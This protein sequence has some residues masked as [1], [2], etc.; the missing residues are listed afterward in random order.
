MDQSRRWVLTALSLKDEQ[1]EAEILAKLS[2]LL[3]RPITEE[4]QVVYFLVEL[5]KALEIRGLFTQYPALRF[6]C[7]WAVHTRMDRAGAEEVLKR[8]D[9]VETADSFGMFGTGGRRLAIAWDFLSQ[10]VFRRDLHEALRGLALQ[11]EI[12]TTN[13]LWVSFVEVYAGVVSDCSLAIKSKNVATEYV[14]EAVVS[15]VTSPLPSDLG[16]DEA[17]PAFA[18]AVEWRIKL[19]RPK[20]GMSEKSYFVFFW[21]DRPP[22]PVDRP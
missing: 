14:E 21:R 18:F 5:R 15:K 1:M 6:Y 2:H 8:I 22:S 20:Y 7:D 12:C 4:C 16:I 17:D 13:D 9:D 11:T 3:S 10:D 19:K